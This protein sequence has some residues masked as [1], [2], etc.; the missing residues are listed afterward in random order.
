M[1][2]TRLVAA[3]AAVK[4]LTWQHAQRSGSN[5]L[6]RNDEFMT[7]ITLRK[8]EPIERALRRLKK[9]FLNNERSQR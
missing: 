2:A 9:Q 6:R 3:T 8:G 1:A 4:K 5:R 7:Q